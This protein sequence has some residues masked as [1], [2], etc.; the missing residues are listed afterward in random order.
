MA[1][2]KVGAP[3]RFVRVTRQSGRKKERMEEPESFLELED[4]TTSETKYIS[5]TRI[6]E[7]ISTIEQ[8]QVGQSMENPNKNTN[9][10]SEHPTEM[11]EKEKHK[12]KVITEEVLVEYITC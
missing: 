12:Q 11:E 1:P 2:P 6:E 7:E 5:P 8:V 10:S 9:P 3:D 4:V